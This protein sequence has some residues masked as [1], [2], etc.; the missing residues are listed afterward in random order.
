MERHVEICMK[1]YYGMKRIGMIAALAMINALMIFISIIKMKTIMLLLL[2]L[3]LMM[4]M[5]IAMAK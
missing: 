2:L 5:K 1:K 3:L 4:M